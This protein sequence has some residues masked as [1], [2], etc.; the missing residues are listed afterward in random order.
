MDMTRK[1]DPVTDPVAGIEGSFTELPSRLRDRVAATS[2]MVGT[3][4]LAGLRRL[5]RSDESDDDALGEA[6]TRELDQLKGLAMKV[7]Q[8]VSYMEVGLP[9]RT[10]ERLA[11][12]QRG[13]TPMEV[14]QVIE[15]LQHSLGG[16]VGRLFERFDPVPVAAASIG[17]V[18]RGRVH[19]R[20]VAVKVRYPGI[21]E[22][23][24][25]DLRQLSS[26][27]SL[28]SLATSVD[29]A[30]LV[31]ELR[32]RALEECD[33]AAEAAHQRRMGEFLNGDPSYRV[34]DVVAD[35]SAGAVLTTTWSDGVPLLDRIDTAGLA[36]ARLPWTT[37]FGRHLL[38]ADP[39]PGNFLVEADGALVVLDH[40][41][42]RLVEP[43]RVLLLRGLF[44]A[45]LRSDRD[46]MMDH[47]RA[48]GLVPEGSRV[49][50]ADLEALLG[51]LMEPY[52]SRE[53]RFERSWW[54]SSM[55]AFRRPGST[56]R[57]LAFPRDWLWVQRALL[58]MHAVLLR[59]TRSWPLGDLARGALS[60]GSAAAS[61]PK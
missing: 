23:L 52:R 32:E 26:L 21:E 2:R 27:A 38:H 16:R 30:A 20:E 55:K 18:H 9:P 29:G 46:G 35:R 14:G 13:V 5:V 61:P 7:G 33:Y 58:G 49:A 10:Q 22:I 17:Q 36:F 56:L 19:G 24:A 50:A 47:A 25:Q 42:T 4:S 53:F 44:G 28:A 6:L 34:P 48:Y 43:S 31:D 3:L 59:S 11:A 15:V 51:F 12:L 60:E 57:H 40:G 39:H 45:A 54:E 41:C 8:I 1:D 37:L